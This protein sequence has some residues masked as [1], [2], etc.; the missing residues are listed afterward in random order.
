MDWDK[1]IKLTPGVRKCTHCARPARPERRRC[2][3]CSKRGVEE[4]RAWLKRLTWPQRREYWK[5]MKRVYRASSPI[6]NY[7]KWLSPQ[8]ETLLNSL[9]KTKSSSYLKDFARRVGSVRRRKVASDALAAW[10]LANVPPD[11]TETP[12]SNT[13]ANTTETT[14]LLS[15][16]QPLEPSKS[17]SLKLPL[18]PLSS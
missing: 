4:K 1:T 18:N 14:T 3:Y 15:V 6:E 11:A 7:S 16:V 5:L 2:I 10:M 9:A 13:C 12:T 17:K 8:D